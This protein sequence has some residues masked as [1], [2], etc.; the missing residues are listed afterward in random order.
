MVGVL[1]VAAYFVIFRELQN[2]SCHCVLVA[3]YV[4]GGLRAGNCTLWIV[5]G[6]PDHCYPAQAAGAL[7]EAEQD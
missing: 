3:G 5:L 6:F 2:G 1:G 4:P 7:P